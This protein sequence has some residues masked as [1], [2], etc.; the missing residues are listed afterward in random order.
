[1]S[2]AA[3]MLGTPFNRVGVGQFQQVNRLQANIKPG[4]WKAQLRALI[5]DLKPQHSLVKRQRPGRIR[6]HQ[7]DMVNIQ[8]GQI[9]PRFYPYL[10]ALIR[11]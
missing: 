8:N 4:T 2:I 11:L 6:H 7:A 9:N 1:M 3:A 5:T 10:E